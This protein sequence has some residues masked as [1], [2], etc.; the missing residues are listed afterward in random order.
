MGDNRWL[1]N[2]FVYLI[3][4]V[5][6]LAL[7][8]QYFGQTSSQ[9]SEKG[10]AEVVAAAK[11]GRIKDIEA[12]AG[13]EQII[14]TYNDNSTFRSRLETSDSIMTLL[15]DYGVPLADESGKQVLN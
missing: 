1:K 6:A 2:S 10:I 11:A 4:L 12:Q 13:D 15:A 7:F 14:V 3:I 8:F 5:A 9:S